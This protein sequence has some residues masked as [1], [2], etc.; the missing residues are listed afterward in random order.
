MNKVP[1]KNQKISEEISVVAHQLKN[2]ISVLKSYLEVLISEDLGKLNQK[3]KEYL[4]DVLENIKRMKE[5]IDNILDVS[6]IEAGKYKIKPQIVDLKKITKEVINDFYSWIKASNSQIVFEFSP[7]ENFFV[8]ADPLRIRQVIE[9]LLSNALKY[10]CNGQGVISIFLKKSGKN[11]LFSCKD[12]G[13]GIA[14]KDKKKVFN[15]FYRS[16]KA[17]EMD[18]NGCGLGLYVTKAIIELSKGKIWFKKNSGRGLTFYF[19]LPIYD[20]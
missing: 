6:K 3:Q 14:S 1:K 20:K 11:I 17:L 18:P 16:E 7:K 13:I 9:G 19:T 8:K 4:S 5:T 15:K 10:K 2:P 12:N